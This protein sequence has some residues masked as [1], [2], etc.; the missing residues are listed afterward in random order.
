MDMQAVKLI[1]QT[2]ASAS[3]YKMKLHVHNFTIYN[4]ITHESDN[5]IWD[6][7][8][9]NLVASTFTTCIIKHLKNCILESPNALISLCIEKNLTI[10]H[11]YL[12]VGHIQMVCDLTHSLIP[13]KINNKRIN[14]P[15]EFVEYVKVRSG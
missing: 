10:E 12:I 15:S 5:Y 14:L 11:K 7:S 4:I 8:E 1:P 9:G 6:E 2:N 13:R 3:Y